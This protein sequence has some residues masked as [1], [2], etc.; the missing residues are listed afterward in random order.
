[1]R[2]SGLAVKML[3]WAVG[4]WRRGNC[5]GCKVRHQE[6]KDGVRRYMKVEIHETVY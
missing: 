6:K 5:T 2:I 4:R 3:G 1:M